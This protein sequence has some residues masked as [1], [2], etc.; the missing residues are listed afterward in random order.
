MTESDKMDLKKLAFRMAALIMSMVTALIVSM[1]VAPI[2]A[3]LFL[4]RPAS[5]SAPGD[6]ILNLLAGR[7][8]IGTDQPGGKLHIVATDDESRALEVGTEQGG[9]DARI[10]GPTSL[11]GQVL[12]DK[13]LEVNGKIQASAPLLMIRTHPTQ[14]NRVIRYQSVSSGVPATIIAGQYTLD[15]QGRAT[16][17]LPE[18]FKLMSSSVI[19]VQLTPFGA[20]LQLYC[21]TANIAQL[22]VREANGKTGKFYYQVT[23]QMS[24]VDVNSRVILDKSEAEAE[25]GTDATALGAD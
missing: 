3:A 2:V 25:F 5:A 7:V 11:M 6:T 14:T 12:V 24:G 10:F 16:V 22:V 8:G 15:R 17:N 23:G 21:E 13:N 1:L 18:H 19:A 4:E 20:P 9:G